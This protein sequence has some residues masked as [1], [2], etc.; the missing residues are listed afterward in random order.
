MLVETTCEQVLRAEILTNENT[1]LGKM[2]FSNLFQVFRG[3]FRKYI[4]KGPFDE[5]S[6]PFSE[7]LHSEEKQY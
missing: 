1:K 4:F 2:M 5:V 6:S 3:Q 7:Y